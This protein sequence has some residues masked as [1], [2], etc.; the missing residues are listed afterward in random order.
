MHCSSPWHEEGARK[1]ALNIASST[2]PWPA[3]HS[4][5]GPYCMRSKQYKTIKTKTKITPLNLA[6]WNICTL[7]YRD[8]SDRPQ[9]RTALIANELARYSID[10]AALS[11]IR[12]TGEGELCKKGAGYTFF[13]S[14]RG[15]EERRE[16][17]VGFAVKLSFVGK[18]VGP[19][20]GVNDRLM[21][22]QFPLS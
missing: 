11:A 12:F 4:C 14:G 3:C 19:E 7:M 17:G 13:W 6:T 18:L 5:Q 1:G 15:P 8:N 9:R 21:T 16:A 10:I 2:P 20:K 22:M